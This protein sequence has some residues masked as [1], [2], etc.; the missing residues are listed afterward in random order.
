MRVYF[1]IVVSTE[2]LSPRQRDYARVL[3]KIF[4]IYEGDVARPI[5]VGCKK[6][7]LGRTV[8]N[9]NGEWDVFINSGVARFRGLTH[10]RLRALRVGISDKTLRSYIM[11]RTNNPE[12]Q[13]SDFFDAVVS[14]ELGHVI[15]HEL[16]V[17]RWGA[18][19]GSSFDASTGCPTKVMPHSEAFAC[20][21]S[22]RVVGVRRPW[23]Y[24][25]VFKEDSLDDLELREC[26]LYEGL[27]DLAQRHG[28]GAA[29]D[30]G[31]LVGSFA[32]HD[33]QARRNRLLYRAA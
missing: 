31:L 25:G 29:F 21:F 23:M 9:D 4:K 2:V 19:I 16:I 13:P 26:R 15:F 1:S 11:F 27:W 10:E 28:H 22:D 3:E 14:H 30:T 20:W 18:L 5:Y 7:S 33:P 17:E 32:E 6:G 24:V 12:C 8:V